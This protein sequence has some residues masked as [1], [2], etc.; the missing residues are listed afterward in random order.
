MIYM[1]LDG[2]P[3]SIND[4][5]MTIKKG[6]IPIRVLTK[7][8]RAYQ[9]EA[10]AS[11]TSKYPME[12]AKFKQNVPYVVAIRLGVPGL[13]TKGWPTKAKSRYKK[14]DATN[15]VKLL[16][17]V[18]AEVTAVDDSANLAV[19]VQK[20]DDVVQYTE[21]FIWEMEQERCPFIDVLFNLQPL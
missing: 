14:L 2:L 9:K 11:L 19:I 3:P 1:K 17:D 18:L 12:L 16:E 4:A 6:K 13:H 21:L 10:K 5:Y 15:R 8:G 20:V 7:E